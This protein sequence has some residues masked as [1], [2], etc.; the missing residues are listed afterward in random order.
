[1]LGPDTHR[2][3]A[4]RRSRGVHRGGARQAGTLRGQ[5]ETPTGATPL[6]CV[7]NPCSYPHTHHPPSN[8]GGG[9]WTGL[10]SRGSDPPLI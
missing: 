8:T 7:L 1:M 2:W 3:I 10:D 5:R 6:R 9:V 4:T